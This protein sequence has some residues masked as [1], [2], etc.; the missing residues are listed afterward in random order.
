MKHEQRRDSFETQY[1]DL[2]VKYWE[3]LEDIVNN[4]ARGMAR[5][6][7]VRVYSAR[8][9]TSAKL[10]LVMMPWA[11]R[12]SR[13]WERVRGLILP[14]DF[15]SSQKRLGP[16]NRSRNNR[17]VHLLPMICM[18]LAMQPTL[19]SIGVFTE[20]IFIALLYIVLAVYLIVSIT[21]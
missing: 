13:R 21:I 14:T 8:G 17:A 3:A 5:P 2:K 20:V 4:H 9:G 16:S 12:S 19:G 18:V 7:W 1:E 10:C 15:S 11:W 6:F